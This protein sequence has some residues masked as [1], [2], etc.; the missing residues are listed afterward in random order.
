[1]NKNLNNDASSLISVLVPMYNTQ[2]TIA[3]CIKSI[4]KQTY[5][6]LEIV[7]LDDGSTDNTYEIAK[8]FAQLDSR[9]KLLSKQNEKNISKTR[10]FLLNN[11]SG[12]YFVWVDSDDVVHKRYVEKLY[13]TI[14]STNSDLGIC[15]YKLKFLNTPLPKK[16]FPKTKEFE[17]EEFYSKIILNHKIGFMLWNK[18]YK[19]ELVEDVRFN[20]SVRYGED[21]AFVFSYIKK[22]KKVAVVN[23]KLYKYIVRPNSEMTKKFSEK[24]ITFV[25][26]LKDLANNETNPK[27][28]TI[29]LTWL[30]FTGNSLLFLAKRSKYENIENL[31]ELYEL[32]H[33]Y[34]NEFYNNKDV[35][36]LHKFVVTLGL[37]TWAKKPPKI[38]QKQT[39]G[40]N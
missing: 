2:K 3:R 17:N 25:D 15:G 22:C 29:L 24:Q 20:E 18:I 38:K 30:S 4:L 28:K 36:I 21:F 1:M 40:E 10:N 7:L 5:S 34:K 9:I 8:T 35:M 27:I 23:E 19:T 31:N 12:D 32:A 6:N 14:A 26:Y 13:K 16:F 33:K 37:K 11:F 39:N